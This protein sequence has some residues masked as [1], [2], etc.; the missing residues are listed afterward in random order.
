MELCEQ[1]VLVE[2][3]I[4]VLSE[5]CSTVVA[6]PKFERVAPFA[7]ASHIDVELRLST[8]DDPGLHDQPP[9]S[10]RESRLADLGAVLASE[11]E[12]PRPCVLS[13]PGANMPA[14]EKRRILIWGKTSP[15]LSS[16]YIETV[17]TGGVFEDG[18]P[19]RLYPIPFRYLDDQD[20]FKKNPSLPAPP[21]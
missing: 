18:A 1:L 8:V 2:E 16:R 9:E 6:L 5:G 3:P 11:L 17:C 4:P 20:R 10:F 21:V 13:M 14:W 7:R 15:Q 19:V 12:W